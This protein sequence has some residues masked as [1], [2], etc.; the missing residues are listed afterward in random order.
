ML[1]L[2]FLNQA[3]IS[4]TRCIAIGRNQLAHFSPYRRFTCTIHCFPFQERGQLSTVHA[5]PPEI[6]FNYYV[7][8]VH[9]QSLFVQP[10]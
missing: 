1:I 5:V 3:V 10:K 9:A 4:L 6:L 7:S 2:N 8:D